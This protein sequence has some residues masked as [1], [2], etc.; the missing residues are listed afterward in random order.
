MGRNNTGGLLSKQCRRIELSYLL[1]SK[2][3]QQGSEV[4]ASLKWTDDSTIN[5]KS[6]WCNEDIYILLDYTHTDYEG[7][8][9]KLS[10]R[11]NITSLPSNLGKGRVLFMVCPLSGRLCRKLFMAYGSSYFKS[12]KAY[13]NRIYYTGQLSSKLDRAND[14]YWQVFN[15]LKKDKS[16]RKQSHYKGIETKRSIRNKKLHERLIVLDYQRWNSMP[17]KLKNSLQELPYF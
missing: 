11:V 12:I 13:Q 3:I 1:E 5:I 15:R 4:E 7:N 6:K 17:L 9:K 10:Y 16:Q 8:K 2:I 14:A